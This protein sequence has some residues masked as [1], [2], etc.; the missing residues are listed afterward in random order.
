M[1]KA[2]YAAFHRPLK[3]G[4]EN[5][6]DLFYTWK[7]ADDMPLALLDQNLLCIAIEVRAEPRAR[8]RTL[9]RYRNGL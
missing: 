7:A 9:V 6:S 1:A 4:Q 5:D 3:G 8:S 2:D